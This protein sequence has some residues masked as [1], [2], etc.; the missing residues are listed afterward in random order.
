MNV[1]ELREAFARGLRERLKEVETEREEIKRSLEFVLKGMAA[2]EDAP[3]K[4]GE[5]TKER[6]LAQSRRMKRLH[7][8]G[9]FR[10]GR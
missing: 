1:R 5:W 3:P 7:R 4:K 6:R 8:Q 2:G 9:V 10:R